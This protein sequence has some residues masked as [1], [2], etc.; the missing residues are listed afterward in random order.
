MDI[1]TLMKNQIILKYEVKSLNEKLDL[2]L[3]ILERVDEGKSLQKYHKYEYA[4][5]DCLFPINSKIYLTSL[6]DQL[7]TDAVYREKMVIILYYLV[8][9]N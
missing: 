6:N 2:V 1:K 9:F 7:R 3:K 5:L 4:N 8:I